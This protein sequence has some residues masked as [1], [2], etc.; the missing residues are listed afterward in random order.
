MTVIGYK[1]VVIVACLLIVGLLAL[2]WHLAIKCAIQKADE[3]GAWLAI[4]DYG[5]CRDAALKS[6]PGGAAEQ[7]YIIVCLP[8]RMTNSP[9]HLLRIVERERDRDIRDVVAYLRTKT[10]DDLGDDPAKWIEKYSP[11]EKN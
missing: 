1:R 8:P 2:A 9:S 4:A 11:H 10:G 7:L 6:E 5:R 3:R